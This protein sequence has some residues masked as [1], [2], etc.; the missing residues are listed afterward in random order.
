M[1]TWNGNFHEKRGSSIHI[2][3]SAPGGMK[4]DRS[5]SF[6]WCILQQ[7]S[8]CYG[9]D[10]P[11]L[12]T[13]LG[14]MNKDI[15][16]CRCELHIFLMAVTVW[17]SHERKWK[18]A[19]LHTTTI[20]CYRYLYV[21]HFLHLSGSTKHHTRLVKIVTDSDLLNDFFPKFY[22]PLNICQWMK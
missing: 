2:F 15:L 22:N 12:P 11:I 13:L 19:D 21:L 16:S 17:L 3:T 8:N 4:R 10:K 9:R 7:L 5:F 18:T 6:C 20:K 1:E 14:L